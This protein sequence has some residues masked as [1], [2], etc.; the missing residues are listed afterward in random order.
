MTKEPSKRHVAVALSLEQFAYRLNKVIE[1]CCAA[2]AAAMILIIWFG[3][4]ERYV[5][6]L[7]MT[8][9][10]ELARYVMIWTAL[11]AVPACAYRREHIGLDVLFS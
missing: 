9:T 4:I 5:F 3:V 2:L 7:G 10:E 8:W 6:H 11:L 1:V